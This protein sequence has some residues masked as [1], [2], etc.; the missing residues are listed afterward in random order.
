M[1]TMMEVLRRRMGRTIR[2]RTWRRMKRRRRRDKVDET[3]ADST[4]VSY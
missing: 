3:A 1:R 2:R 4:M